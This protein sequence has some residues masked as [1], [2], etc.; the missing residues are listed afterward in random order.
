MPYE[1]PFTSTPEIEHLAMEI[2]ELVGQVATTSALN[3]NP[4]LR[5]EL[6]IRTIHSTLVIEGN[7]LSGH[8]V[9]AIMDGKP[10]LGPARDIREAQNATHAYELLGELNPLNVT[11]LLR[12]HGVMMDGLMPDAGTFRSKNAG[13][14]QGE[15]L[16]HAGTSTRYVPDIVADLIHWLSTTNTHP[17]I[18]SCIFHY[19][20]EFIHP[21]SD[22]NGRVGRLWHTL[23]LARWREQLQWLPVERVILER[24]AQ[25]YSALQEANS[26][27]DAQPFVTFIL[28]AIRDS[29]AAFA[30]APRAP[31]PRAVDERTQRE[32]IAL[33]YFADNPHGTV[34]ALA[35]ILG[36]S[37][38][39]AEC[40][41][42][43]LVRRGL[44]RRVGRPRAGYWEVKRQPSPTLT[45]PEDPL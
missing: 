11:D 4:R 33:T 10:V 17:L 19:E 8:I 21:F 14:Y 41:V 43:H 38:S 42:K 1:P 34:R 15:R 25:Y 9:S 13:V 2:A 20:F 31:A 39:T 5:R 26:I 3:G 16:I 37:Q 24:Q 27:S 29:L 30:P 6:R 23:V 32:H 44:L 35:T 28:T 40:L 7:S 12:A 36:C 45:L 22:G 18:A